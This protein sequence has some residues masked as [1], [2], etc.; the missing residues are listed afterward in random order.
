[1]SAWV[2]STCAQVRPRASKASSYSRISRLWPAAAAA[3]L[4]AIPRGREASR[5]RST[6]RTTAPLDTR[7]GTR[8]PPPATAATSSQSAEN[9]SRSSVGAPACPPRPASTAEPILIT[10]RRDWAS[11]VRG[12]CVIESASALPYDSKAPD[13]VQGPELF[14]AQAGGLDVVAVGVEDERRVVRLAVAR[15]W[16]RFSVV[17]TAGRERRRVEALDGGAVVRLEG[18]VE[19]APGPASAEPQLRRAGLAEPGGSGLL[20]VRLEAVPERLQGGAVEP[21]APGE[22]RNRQSDVVE[23]GFLHG[24]EPAR[25]RVARG[26]AWRKLRSLP[27]GRLRRRVLPSRMRAMTVAVRQT[28]CAPGICMTDVLCS[29]G[30]ADAPF[31]E[32]HGIAS[33]AFVTQG[34]FGYRC[35]AGTAALGPGAVLLGNA[36]SAYT[37]THAAPGGDRCLSFGYSAEVVEEVAASAGS[38]GRFRRAVLPAAPA[39]AAQDP[40]ACLGSV[41]M[42]RPTARPPR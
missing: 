32:W 15:P 6:P 8:A 28:R 17:F 42:V 22:I 23:H 31:E 4:S 34:G 10:G 27:R 11:W 41:H 39:L 2:S 13:P 36:G 25:Y 29:A 37:C 33:V 20:V 9:R 30:P 3:C 12:L 1:M 14:R 7:T 26:A 24:V 21:Q 16:P 18:Q 19:R 35:S 38:T 5:R 40:F